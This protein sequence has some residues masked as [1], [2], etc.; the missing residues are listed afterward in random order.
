MEESEVITRD[1]AFNME[2]DKAAENEKK[3][4]SV[5]SDKHTVE[6]NMGEP[7]E[8]EVAN[9]QDKDGEEDALLREIELQLEKGGDDVGNNDICLDKL[10]DNEED[11]LLK[12]T[13]DDE[14]E[15]NK[16][17]K[18]INP[19][20]DI[21]G[22]VDKCEVGSNES[23]PESTADNEPD[24]QN[25]INE[26]KENRLNESEE[27]KIVENKDDE[28]QENKE[29]AQIENEDKVI[30]S[31]E[32]KLIENEGDKLIENKENELNEKEECKLAESGKGNSI[33]SEE[34]EEDRLLEN[35][36]NELIESKENKVAKNDG[37]KVTES[38]ENVINENDENNRLIKNRESE[39]ENTS[40][41]DSE[42]LEEQIALNSVFL[43]EEIDLDPV[44]DEVFENESDYANMDSRDI[45]MRYTEHDD[46]SDD[47]MEID[48]TVSQEQNAEGE[49]SNDG[50][51][52]SSNEM[53]QE[54]SISGDSGRNITDETNQERSA[55]GG[56]SSDS[57]AVDKRLLE[58]DDSDDRIII[59]D[60]LNEMKRNNGRSLNFIKEGAA[61]ILLSSTKNV[62]YNPVQEFNRD[63][64][65]CALTVFSEDHQKDPHYKKRGLKRKSCEDDDSDSHVNK[66]NEPA[67]VPGKQVENGMTI[68]EALS[69]T[70]LRSIRYAKEVPG[71]K[72]IIANDLSS[73]A[74]ETIQKNIEHN[75]VTDLV[76][77]TKSDA[78]LLMYQHQA[79]GEW[80]DAIDI[81]P[82][83][84]P[85][86]FLDAAVQAVRDGGMLLVTC[87]DMAVLAGN[88]PETCHAKY[89]AV[90]LRI[91]ACHEMA[92]RIA[93]Q[94][95]E[96][97]ANRYGR[98]IVPLL[99]IS[100]D[101][102]IRVI[103]LVYT[104]PVTCKKTTSKLSMVYQCVGCHALTLHPLG[105]ATQVGSTNTQVKFSLPASPPVNTICSHCGFK[106]R[107]GGPIWTGP[108]HSMKFVERMLVLAEKTGFSTQKRMEGMLEVIREELPDVP[109]YYTAAGLCS[110]IHCSTVPLISIKSAL[111]NAGYRVSLSH[112]NPAS[113]KTNAPIKV[114]WDVIRCWVRLHP[115]SMKRMTDGSVAAAILCRPPTLLA[116]F[117]EH[118]KARP[119]SRVRGLLRFQQ[120]P[121]RNWG[122][123]MRGRAN[124]SQDETEEKRRSNQNKRTK[125]DRRRGNIDII[126]VVTLSTDEDEGSNQP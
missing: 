66:E 126:E 7:E 117:T 122:P 50:F 24:V 87:T 115:V 102:Y 32:D 23:T 73:A 81:D 54:Q 45:E 15:E 47:S 118:H 67:L 97:H 94:C 51:V 25:S 104:S 68:L 84:C 12:S 3:N 49:E 20:N 98:Y 116:D 82:Y 18:N 121:Q 56:D 107:M 75:E 58:P 62:F 93:L 112:A 53:N 110:K 86:R 8:A 90:S 124:Y 4:E 34:N 88:S 92:I 29:D 80:Y 91:S 37:D 106:H 10:S 111:L 27:S 1:S 74:V 63:L 109:L 96:S 35:E 22:V 60:C 70:G 125:R 9:S 19:D 61:E 105:V 83:G 77:T 46:R 6:Q 103:V 31:E 17:V 76:V 101:F 48:N 2:D 57:F 52:N 99:S 16:S 41:F 114:L 65:V 42:K 95:I 39:N 36:E 69:A 72:K 26:N 71:V 43:K 64:S 14:K 28:F 59:E 120:N 108:I 78:A 30:Q 44:G 123:G 55:A 38:E 5:V 11:Q 119:N 79:N 113:I 13:S 100:A 40:E 33:V 89:G 85:S 21:D